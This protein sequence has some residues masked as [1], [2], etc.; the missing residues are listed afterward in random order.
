MATTSSLLQ[1]LE[2]ARSA[3]EVAKAVKALRT[4]G[5]N[6]AAAQLEAEC[7]RACAAVVRTA[8]RRRASAARARAARR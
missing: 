4:S 3:Q 6:T 5:N 1:L 2:V 8:Q 7:N